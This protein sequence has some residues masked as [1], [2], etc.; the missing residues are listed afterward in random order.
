MNIELT[1]RELLL[2][3]FGLDTIDQIQPQ[4][5]L[6]K[7]L[8]ATS[9]DFVEISYIVESNFNVVIKTNEL[10]IGGT[11][12]N[13]DDIFIE[14]ILTTE[15]A[16]ILNKN[17]NN[18]RFHEGQTKRDLFEAITVTDLAYIISTRMTKKD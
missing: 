4:Q 16:A 17:L 13:P 18:N 15:G 3:V 10:M 6:V 1:L 7:D 2:P 11:S 5:T 12:V 14:G 9:I 8:G